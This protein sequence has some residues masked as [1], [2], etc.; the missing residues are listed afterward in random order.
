MDRHRI[1]EKT[2][3]I[4]PPSRFRL[5]LLLVTLCLTEELAG[6]VSLFCRPP[7][8]LLLRP[9]LHPN[10][11]VCVRGLHCETEFTKLSF[12][13]GVSGVLREE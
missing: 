2:H 6:A 5:W 9:P 12:L 13:W 1:P 10:S 11:C 3:V 8:L 7:S 4:H